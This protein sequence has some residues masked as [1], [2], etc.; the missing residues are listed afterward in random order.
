MSG[1][2]R[3]SGGSS[4]GSG[5]N[6]GGG[7]SS[8]SRGHSYTNVRLSHCMHESSPLTRRSLPRE[9]AHLLYL[10]K[11]TATIHETIPYTHKCNAHHG[12]TTRTPTA[13]EA[14]KLHTPHLPL[15]DLKFSNLAPT[16]VHISLRRFTRPLTCASPLG[17]S[18]RATSTHRRRLT[19]LRRRSAVRSRI[20]T[21]LPLV[22]V[23]PLQLRPNAPGPT[24]PSA[25][26]DV[27]VRCSIG[28]KC[29]R[30]I[31]RTTHTLI[32]MDNNDLTEVTEHRMERQHDGTIQDER[33]IGFLIFMSMVVEGEWGPTG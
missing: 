9:E 11:A 31:G 22:V 29:M 12:P 5:R 24:T 19:H 1:S 18:Q 13:R 15:K 21:S 28:M 26:S 27:T 3:R 4:N 30:S 20:R 16:T 10:H 23:L 32:N 7:R 6:G 2:Q 33:R 14:T 25:T 8:S 17:N